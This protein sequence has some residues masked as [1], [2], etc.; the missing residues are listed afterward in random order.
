[1]VKKYDSYKNADSY[2]FRATDIN[3]YN[4]SSYAP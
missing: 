3:R 4:R 2:E 1:M